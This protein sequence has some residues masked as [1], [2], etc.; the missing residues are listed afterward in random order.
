MTKEKKKLFIA[1][2][3]LLAVALSFFLVTGLKKAEKDKRDAV[4][5]EIRKNQQNITISFVPND[6]SPS[7]R[8]V[9]HMISL[10]D[11]KDVSLAD[12]QAKGKVENP[13]PVDT[14]T[15]KAVVENEAGIDAQPVSS[16]AETVYEVAKG[17]DG[18][19]SIKVD[20][21]E[22]LLYDVLLKY[23]SLDQTHDTVKA[24]TISTKMAQQIGYVPSYSDDNIDIT[25]DFKTSTINID[26]SHLKKSFILRFEPEI[27][28]KLLP[29]RPHDMITEIPIDVANNFVT[30]INVDGVSEN[31]EDISDRLFYYNKMSA[32]TYIITGSDFKATLRTN[33]SSDDGGF[34]YKWY[35]ANGEEVGTDPELSVSLKKVKESTL[36]T[37]V[38]TDAYNSMQRLF[39]RLDVNEPQKEE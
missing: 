24:M 8:M 31:S 6:K 34:T 16:T 19:M 5:E 39:F 4:V 18:I 22:S 30:S 27:N 37:C 2:G 32:R 23:D 17:Y 29:E 20:M 15:F 7:T 3:I 14:P 9:E 11:G 13:Y 38:V 1:V 26:V 35:N 21:V 12:V 36:F 28:E 33:A 10:N 25:F